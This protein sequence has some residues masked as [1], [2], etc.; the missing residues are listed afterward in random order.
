M[1]RLLTAT[2]VASEGFFCIVEVQPL[3]TSLF[4]EVLPGLGSLDEQVTGVMNEQY[5]LC[6]T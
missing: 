2:C 3:S 6:S 1:A 4:P 5:L